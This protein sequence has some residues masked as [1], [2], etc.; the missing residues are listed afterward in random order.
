MTFLEKLSS[1]SSSIYYAS[2]VTGYFNDLN[3]QSGGRRGVHVN[4]LDDE[5]LYNDF[6]YFKSLSDVRLENDRRFGVPLIIWACLFEREIESR[7][8]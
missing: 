2:I 3:Y 8:L 5:I 4:T 1:G 6:K 7:G